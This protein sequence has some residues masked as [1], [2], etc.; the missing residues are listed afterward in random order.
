MNP[1]CPPWCRH[2]PGHDITADNA[3]IERTHSALF[4]RAPVEVEIVQTDA[5]A[6]VSGPVVAG[7]PHIDVWIGGDS[8]GSGLVA[9]EARALAAALGEAAATLESGQFGHFEPVAGRSALR[10]EVDAARKTLHAVDH[11]RGRV[12]AE[13]LLDR[14]ASVLEALI[15]TARD[16]LEAAGE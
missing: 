9:A 2:A 11:Q 12:N 6:S 14:T 7:D 13:W 16:H 8:A 4:G 1:V 15:G 3:T 10:R 5:A